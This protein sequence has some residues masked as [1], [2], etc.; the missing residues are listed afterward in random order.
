MPTKSGGKAIASQHHLIT[1]EFM[2]EEKKILTF[3]ERL[4]QKSTY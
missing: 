4:S 3:S 1:G 2:Q